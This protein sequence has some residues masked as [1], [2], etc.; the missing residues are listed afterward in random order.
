M[1]RGPLRAVLWALGAVGMAWVIIWAIALGTMG[2]MMGAGPMGGPGTM[3]P[4]PAGGAAMSPSM[5][6]GAIALAGGGMLLQLVGMT[7]LA[8]IFVYLIVDTLRGRSRS[9]R[10]P[11][12]PE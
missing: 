5:G 9:G 4:A 6:G 2:G 8:G 3:G 12:A 7:G 11:E 10:R 1:V